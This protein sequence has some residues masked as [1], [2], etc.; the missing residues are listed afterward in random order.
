[1]ITARYDWLFDKV[2]TYASRFEEF[3]E[4]YAENSALVDCSAARKSF[5]WRLDL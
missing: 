3:V 2:T 1:M 5:E 4:M